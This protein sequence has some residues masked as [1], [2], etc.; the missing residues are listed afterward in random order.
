MNQLFNRILTTMFTVIS[1]TLGLYAI[2]FA[3]A[4]FGPNANPVPVFADATIP[5]YTSLTLTADHFFGYGD[6][7]LN[8]HLTIEVPF[9]AERVSLKVWTPF[10][11]AFEV[12]QNV[13][14]QRDMQNGS[15]SGMLPIGDIYVQTRMSILR[16]KQYLPAIVLNATLK[17]AA[18]DNNLHRRYF[19]T[20]GYY[21]DVEIGKSFHFNSLI[22]NELRLVADLGFICWET[23]G[24]QDDAPMYGG[25]VVL[26]N[27]WLSIANTLAG[28]AGWMGNG[29]TPLVYTT[30]WVWKGSR[31]SYLVEYQYG[32]KDFPYHHIAA[33]VMLSIP[34]LTP[35]YK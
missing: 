35:S 2:E 26:G 12:S 15:R 8:G 22:I 23:I 21:F 34:A 18:V 28:Y 16:E 25:S 7:T 10:A 14:N 4:H 27:K 9:V 13:Y 31:I 20:P 29:D 33:G 24:R 32:I 5:A 30:Q 1:T 6:R 3:P 17:T 11:E 19:D